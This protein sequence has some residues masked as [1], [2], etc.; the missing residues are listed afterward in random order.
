MN[1]KEMRAKEMRK[2]RCVVTSNNSIGREYIIN[3]RNALKAASEFGRCEFGEIVLIT[4]ISGKPVC[5]A[6]YTP[7]NGGRYYRVCV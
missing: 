4:T 1:M 3:H 7:E 5:G 6:A 2:Y